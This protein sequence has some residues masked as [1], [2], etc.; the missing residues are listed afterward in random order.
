M[1]SLTSETIAR[2]WDDF[3]AREETLLRQ[4][5]ADR[6]GANPPPRVP[7]H[8]V[9]TYFFAFRSQTLAKAVEEISYH[10]T[11]GIKNPPKGRC[12]NNARRV[13]PGWT[14]STRRAGSVCS[15][16]RFRSR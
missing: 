16:S 9:A 4:V 5:V 14:R 13:R 8:I 15:T 2:L 12:S 7:D 6:L 1:S 11:S 10:A 3:D